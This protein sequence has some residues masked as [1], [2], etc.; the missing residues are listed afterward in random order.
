MKN[1]PE[2]F[3]K[4]YPDPVYRK[5]IQTQIL[6]DIES[7]DPERMQWDDIEVTSKDGSKRIVSAKN[8]PLFDQDFMIS[9]V[10]DITER[11]QAEAELRKK[12]AML[13]TSPLRFP[14]CSTSL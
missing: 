11:K 8:I 10:Q 1:I 12:D 5:K 14:G 7:G 9:T 4:V 3:E 2:F 13:E 6:A